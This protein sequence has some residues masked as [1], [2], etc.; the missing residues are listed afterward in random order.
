M[1]L[2]MLFLRY[3]LYRYYKLNSHQRPR[4]RDH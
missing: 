3:Q 2:L 1:P 4:C